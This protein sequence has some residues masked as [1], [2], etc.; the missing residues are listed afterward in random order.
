MASPPH[1]GTLREKSLHASLKEW[2]AEPGDRFEVKVDRYVIDV[3]RDDLLIEIQTRGFS[4]MK[5]KLTRLLDLG[6]RVR[7]IHPIP[8]TKTIV[9]LGEDGEILGRRRSPK[10]GSALDIFGE[11][12][13]IPILAADPNLE[14]VL[15]LTAEDEYRKQ[16]E[17]R[18][19]RR[20][21]WVVQER[22]LVEVL[23]VVAIADPADLL[24]LLPTDLPE[25]FTTADLAAAAGCPR[26]VAQQA[27]YCLRN[28]GV[29]A[30]V[31]KDGNAITYRLA[32]S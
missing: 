27:A 11:L 24:P 15:V 1:I 12:V 32:G 6:Y 9:R 13:S 23:D 19:W 14:I 4:S 5:K 28:M 7:I 10:R 30:M 25:P 2:C 20:H 29:A 8:A 17:N 3:V 16:E 22:R 18:A 26:R 21:G 31:G